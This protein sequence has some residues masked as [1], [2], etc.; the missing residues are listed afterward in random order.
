MFLPNAKHSSKILW[1]DSSRHVADNFQNQ[2]ASQ[3]RTLAIIKDDLQNDS[4]HNKQFSSLLS[5][6]SW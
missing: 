4:F 5:N 3:L 1:N 6:D 2:L